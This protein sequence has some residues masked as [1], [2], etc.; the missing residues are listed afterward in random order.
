MP[1]LMG[2]THSV[3]DP[4]SRFRFLQYVP[5]LQEA[6]WDVSHRP[7]APSRYYKFT[8]AFR[9]I[10]SIQRKTAV[11]LRKLS[12]LRDIRDAAD[13]DVIFLNRDLLAGQIWWE[14]QLFRRNPKV[15]FDFDD[16]IYLGDQ[17]H[18]H[19]EWICRKAAWVTAGNETLAAFARQ[20]TERVTILPTVVD[21][22]RYR[23]H[24]HD[25]VHRPVRVGWMGSELSIQET[26]Y[27]H[28]A[29]LTRLQQRLNFD[30]VI[31][32]APGPVVPECGLRW[33]F[34]PW[35]PDVEIDLA[36]HIDIGLMPLVDNEFQRGKCGLKLLQYMAAAVP[37]VATPIGVNRQIIRHGQTGMLASTEQEWAR[38]LEVLVADAELRRRLGMAGRVFC[39]A[40]YS[41]RKWFPVLMEICTTI[42]K[43]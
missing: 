16:A 7:N 27:P 41:L 33:K 8:G 24:S 12:R 36:E 14:Q 38:S 3:V 5:L 4:A 42:S 1:R 19:I 10:R 13:C 22:S 37:A 9:W 17:R 30:F 40:H 29:M 31:V 43:E 21:V 11:T 35:S 25:V 2:C 23:C 20:F 39:E 28:L 15:I 32:S 6:G 26:L 34:I 18:R